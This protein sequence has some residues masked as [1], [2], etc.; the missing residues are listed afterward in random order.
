MNYNWDE[1]KTYFSN[2]NRIDIPYPGVLMNTSSPDVLISE[3]LLSSFIE[4]DRFNSTQTQ[5]V[6][7]TSSSYFDVVG[8]IPEHGF[9]VIFK[10]RSVFECFVDSSVLTKDSFLP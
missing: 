1:D 8:T 4:K 5:V 2:Y 7:K 6:W 10:N 9:Y 3:N